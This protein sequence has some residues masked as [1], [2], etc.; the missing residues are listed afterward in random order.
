MITHR[1]QQ[2]IVQNGG[3]GLPPVI[4]PQPQKILL[5]KGEF[6]GHGKVLCEI[7]TPYDGYK[8]GDTFCPFPCRRLKIPS[9][10]KKG[11]TRD[12]VSLWN[13][14]YDKIRYPANEEMCGKQCADN[15]NCTQSEMDQIEICKGI[16]DGT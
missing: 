1:L 2:I 9:F 16:M 13:W 5:K 15:S 4:Q 14:A 11:D 7:H 3:M 8:E 12:P 10:Q 6:V